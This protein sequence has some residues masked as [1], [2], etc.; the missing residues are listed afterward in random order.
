M[1]L[2]IE[3]PKESTK[4]L[5]EVIISSVTSQDT[6]SLYKNQLLFYIL[7]VKKYRNK[8]LKIPF[9]IPKRIKYSGIHL[10]KEA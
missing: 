2:D 7:A 1:T 4:K 5:L 10:M 6:S 8:V 3:N 9:T